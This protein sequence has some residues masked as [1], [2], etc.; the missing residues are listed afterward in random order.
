LQELTATINERLNLANDYTTKI[1]HV[2]RG[3]E[4]SCTLGS[5]DGIGESSSRMTDCCDIVGV[6]SERRT[7]FLTLECSISLTHS[8]KRLR[9]ELF[10]FWRAIRPQVAAVGELK[11]VGL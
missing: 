11:S 2:S 4:A 8:V 10:Q 9:A 7:K 1:Q 3:V 5:V 6:Y